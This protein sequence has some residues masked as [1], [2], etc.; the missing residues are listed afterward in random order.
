MQISCQE[1]REGI[2]SY[3]WGGQPY[4][5]A[6]TPL[7]NFNALNWKK[8]ITY[9]N[10]QILTA[11]LIIFPLIYWALLIQALHS[12]EFFFCL[13]S[14]P[15]IW[16]PSLQS[17]VIWDFDLINSWGIQLSGSLNTF[18]KRALQL[19]VRPELYISVLTKCCWGWHT[20]ENLL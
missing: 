8:C 14:S 4:V 5:P 9:V 1:K 10:A 16:T 15:C 2:S 7:N 20:P 3:Q 6:L 18:W 19:N 11:L 17:A 12:K 13:S